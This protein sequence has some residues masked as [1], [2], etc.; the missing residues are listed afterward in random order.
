MTIQV[1]EDLTQAAEDYP[2]VYLK[3]EFVEVA[4]P[5]NKINKNDD[6]TFRIK[7]TNSGPLDAK[8]LTLLVEGLNGTQVKSNGAAATFGSSFPLTA[9]F[10]GT[11]PAHNADSPVVT[12]GNKFHFKPTNVSS[13]LEDL[14]KVSVTGWNFDLNHIEINHSRADPLAESTFS[15]IVDAI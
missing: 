13:T 7:I 4:F 14:V 15:S 11:I 10:L 2:H 1:L 3:L 8:D 5:G 9:T 12:G 6:C